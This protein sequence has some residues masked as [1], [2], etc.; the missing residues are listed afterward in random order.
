MC[1]RVRSQTMSGLHLHLINKIGNV[2]AYVHTPLASNLIKQSES[3]RVF[4]DTS[5]TWYK[6]QWNE[7]LQIFRIL[8]WISLEQ[9]WFTINCTVLDWL[10]QVTIEGKK[11][12]AIN[13]LWLSTDYDE[14]LYMLSV[15][16][17]CTLLSYNQ[18][19]NIRTMPWNKNHS[20]ID[21]SR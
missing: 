3:S 5:Q 7:S 1:K 6:Q 2:V 14:K 17:E 18:A 10:S 12:N 4:D 21:E 11:K 19:K 8:P 15:Y 20:R 13:Q 9:W 16:L